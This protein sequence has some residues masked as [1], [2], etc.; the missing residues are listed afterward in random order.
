[1][2]TQK[3]HGTRMHIG[4]G[5][6]DC[7]FLFRSDLIEQLL[8]RVYT[9]LRLHEQIMDLQTLFLFFETKLKAQRALN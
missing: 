4:H 8:W 5:V 9:L 7:N 6:D 1:M 2:Y 3:H